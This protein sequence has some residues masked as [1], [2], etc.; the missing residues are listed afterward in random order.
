MR[1]VVG[2]DIHRPTGHVASNGMAS[3]STFRSLA[4]IAVRFVFIF[5]LPI[6]PRARLKNVANAPRSDAA[7]DGAD[8]R[9][10][11]PRI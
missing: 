8:R 10:A 4:P 9:I 1:R 11:V 7:N 2:N 6:T 5:V 3:R